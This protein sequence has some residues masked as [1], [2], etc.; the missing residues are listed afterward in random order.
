MGL[1]RFGGDRRIVHA[2]GRAIECRPPTVETLR[3]FLTVYGAQVYAL[4]VHA[5]S[6]QGEAVSVAAVVELFA[7][8]PLAWWVLATCAEPVG[9]HWSDLETFGRSSLV[10]I[11]TACM[12]MCNVE[13]CAKAIETKEPGPQSAVPDV[14]AH[15]VMI[16]EL[17]KA[18]HCAPHDVL[19][20]PVESWLS[21]L[22]VANFQAGDAQAEP[23]EYDLSSLPGVSYTRGSNV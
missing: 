10:A 22:E 6:S 15:D 1:D 2:G 7:A 23:V 21:A 11:A 3:R 16:C 14:D 8:E 19:L 12:S 18:Y 9:G 4:S 17:A 5:R 20:W 13:R